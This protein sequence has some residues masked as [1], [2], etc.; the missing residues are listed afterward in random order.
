MA[1]F[2]APDQ[3]PD[4]SW[5]EPPGPPPGEPY[6]SPQSWATPPTSVS[7]PLPPW[8][9]R[10]GEP[11]APAADTGPSHDR[12]PSPGRARHRALTGVLA[13]SM[14]VAGSV[15]GGIVGSRLAGRGS[16]P[17]QAT[18]AQSV[19]DHTSSSGT[20][21]TSGTAGTANVA[22]GS[23]IDAETVLA[24]MTNSVVAIQAQVV[25]GNGPWASQGEDAGT[26][27]VIDNSGDI[28][29]N[30][31][32]V[33]GAQSITVSLPGS[34]ATRPATLL[35][36]NTNRDIAVVHVSDTSQL[37]PATL[38]PR[39]N[40]QVGE[41]V[42]AIG[43]ALAL[44]GSMTVTQ[45]IVSALDRSIQTD[46][47]SL[48]G[49]LQTDAAISSG[50][51]GGPLVDARGTV[52]GMNTAVASSN[53]QNQASNIGFAIPIRS[54]LNVAANLMQSGGQ[55]SGGQVS[56]GQVPGGQMYQGQIPNNPAGGSTVS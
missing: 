18:S 33:A 56:G 48:T 37:S 21:G 27:I 12:K 51:S 52:I 3:P 7:P 13:A 20:S 1:P 41:G 54:A 9:G 5:W 31:H 24:K 36:A 32:V 4:P 14:L 6:H 30:A 45:G 15:G 10:P 29:T 50:N 26:G 46:A 47:S 44:K 23:Q 16:A 43:N 34:T 38:A 53:G 42:V 28:L 17:Q 25:S 8:P 11:P 2:D 40:A 55:V 35:G 39:D 22:D 49:L 19:A